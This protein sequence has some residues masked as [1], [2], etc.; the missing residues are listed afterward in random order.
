MVGAL[1]AQEGTTVGMASICFCASVRIG[2]T[3]D[4]HSED[5]QQRKL[6]G[7]KMTKFLTDEL[8]ADTCPCKKRLC[9]PHLFFSSGLIVSLM[10]KALAHV[11]VSDPC[12][13]RKMP[14]IQPSTPGPGSPQEIKK[15]LENPKK[16]DRPCSRLR[17]DMPCGACVS[18]D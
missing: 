18:V 11:S 1:P 17:C 7:K 8:Y 14:K 9:P 10:L 6:Q 13:A 5:L 16:P 4:S 15:Q 12:D 2:W 3:L